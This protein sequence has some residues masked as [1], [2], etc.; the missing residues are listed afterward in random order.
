MK[1]LTKTIVAT[2]LL[3]CT[4]L[5]MN[6]QTSMDYTIMIPDIEF[7]P[8]VTIDINVN[9][10]V[11][12]N[13][14]NWANHG[15]IFAIEGMAHSANCF[16]PLAEELFLNGP[17]G[18]HLNEFFAIDMP[19]R[20]GSGLPVGD[21]FLLEDMYLEDYLAVIEGALSYLNN[22]LNI[23]PRTIMG[24]SMGGL[25]V[26]LLQ[27]KLVNEGTNLKK[28]Y[29]IKNAL[30]LAPAIPAPVDWAYINGGGSSAL[31]PYVA[32]SPDYGIYLDLPY[33]F[34]P[35]VFFTNTCCYYPPNHPETEYMVPGAPLPQEVS[36][37]GYN[38][39]EAGPI[40]LQLS[41]M[42]PA[43]LGLPPSAYPNKPRPE[44]DE[45]IFKPKNGVQLTIVCDEFDKM[46]Y[47][48]DEWNLYKYLTKDKHGKR[49]F[50]VLGEETC[51]DTHIA[52]P[53]AIVELLNKPSIFKETEIEEE[54]VFTKKI[55]VFPNPVEANATIEVEMDRSENIQL[56]VYNQIGQIVKTIYSG[57]LNKGS[58]VFQLPTGKLHAGLY[59]LL[60]KRGNNSEVIKFIKTN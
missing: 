49:F 36:D 52:D 34:W 43:A 25:E 51:H 8:G 7:Q 6:A 9:V 48:D 22:E 30:L 18:A 5:F 4:V 19:G 44:V 10:Y 16:K 32:Y 29:M 20:G 47:P 45:G 37:E 1:T 15:K 21:G 56:L 33:T 28:K 23:Y 54:E 17:Q 14:T 39:I 13:A 3:L 35:G 40:L 38:S 53:H 41:G 2:A 42:N 57:N 11:N 58:H 31:V 12:E 50:V 26:I 55:T 46:M 27:N 24:H 60:V 59:T